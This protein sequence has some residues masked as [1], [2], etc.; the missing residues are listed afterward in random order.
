MMDKIVEEGE[1]QE[2]YFSGGGKCREINK[3]LSV[4]DLLAIRDRNCPLNYLMQFIDV[5]RPIVIDQGV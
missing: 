3:N 4:R 5:Q 1:S 2:V